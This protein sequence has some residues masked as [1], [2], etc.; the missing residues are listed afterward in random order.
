MRSF[1][2]LFFLIFSYGSADGENLK[3][4][5]GIIA[6]SNSYAS[7]AA[8]EI[9]KKGGNAI[10]ASIAVQLVLTLTEPQATGIGGGAFI[11]YWD[12][13]ESK[14]FSI[15]GREK[16][17]SK[18]GEDLFLNKDGKKIKFYPD[19][20]V[21]AKSVGVPGIIKLLEEAHKKFGK[22]QWG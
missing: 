1:F 11:L 12:A 15:D 7:E 8:F 20:V 10:D 17:P 22:L 16:A 2:L 21:G 13:K 4:S 3:P 6:T 5:R 9:I 18:A 19:A 14:L